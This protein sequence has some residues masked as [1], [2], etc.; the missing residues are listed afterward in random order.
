[1]DK[2][3]K[4]FWND[5]EGSCSKIVTIFDDSRPDLV[6]VV[7]EYGCDMEVLESELTKVVAY[8]VNPSS[9]AS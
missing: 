6:R 7:D 2:N 4:Y 3:S 9:D 8:T 5:P 1:M